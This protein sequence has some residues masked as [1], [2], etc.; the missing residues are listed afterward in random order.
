MVSLRVAVSLCIAYLS[1]LVAAI[2]LEDIPKCSLPCV[3]QVMS[4]PAVANSSIEAMCAARELEKSIQDCISDMCTI[5]ESLEFADFV[6]KVCDIPQEDD[7][8]K[9][10]AIVITWAAISLVAIIL[11]LTSKIFVATPWGLDD[12]FSVLTFCILVPCTI[13]FLRATDG[14]FGSLKTLYQSADFSPLLKD[15]FIWQILFIAG[16]ACAKTSILLFYLRIFPGQKFR[17]MVWTTLAFNTIATMVLLAVQL[18]VGRIIELVW[19]RED[20]SAS[21]EKYKKPIIIILAHCVV[22]FCVDVWM[23]VLPMTQLYNLGLRTDKKIRVMCMFGIGIFLT[24]VSLVRLIM[25]AQVV[26]NPSETDSKLHSTVIWAII[27]LNVG[28]IVAVIAPIRQL[29][30]LIAA[31]GKSRDESTANRS[32]SRTATFVDRSLV[33]IKDVDEEQDTTKK[34]DGDDVE[35]SQLGTINNGKGQQ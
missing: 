15:M 11:L 17:R 34:H 14:G 2:S 1:Y 12:S 7:R 30:Q 28:L 18:T 20:L 3:I 22:D 6:S 5:R 19:D 13:F 25:Q 33:R 21:M 31:S 27:E 16:L 32:R 9:Y 4:N 10:R 24:A 8:P 23:L 26:P 35:L 29:F